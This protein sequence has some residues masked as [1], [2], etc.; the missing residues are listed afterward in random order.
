M[1]LSMAAASGCGQ[2]AQDAA[3][4]SDGSPPAYESPRVKRAAIARGLY[5]LVYSRR[6]G[7]V[8]V[9]SSGGFGE[10]AAP[11]RVYRLD[12]DTLEVRQQIELP[13]EGFGLALDD[14]G[15][16]L[17]VGHGIAG[18]LSVIDTAANRLLGTLQYQHGIGGEG[19]EVRAPYHTRQLVL[20]ADSHRLYAPGMS[21]DAPSVLFVIDTRDLSL[22]KTLEGFGMGAV[23]I[24]LDGPGRR[25]FV[26]NFEGE[27]IT[28]DTA[29]LDIVARHA[30]AWSSR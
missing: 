20:D 19:D 21:I 15:D 2:G 13:A 30:P 5:E 7:A 1:L 6:Q 17:Y 14:A 4:P 11:S 9:A 16:R 12:P 18:A 22:E 27:V 23:G 24:A 29:S 26:S 25:L 28:V 10:G 3:A 8:F